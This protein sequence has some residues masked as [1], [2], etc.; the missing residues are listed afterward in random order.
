MISSEKPSA[1]YIQSLFDKLAPRYDL[2]NHLT[3]LGMAG[4]WRRKALEP[5]QAGMRVLDLGCGTG[6]LALDALRKMSSGEVVG[7][8]FSGAML[9][10]AR[11]RHARSGLNGKVRFRLVQKKAEELPFESEPYDVVVSGFVL[12]NIYE[13]IDAILSGVR[14]SLKNGG[15]IRFLDITEP[16]NAAARSFWKFYMRTFAALYGAVLFGKDYPPAYLTESAARFPRAKAFAK[17]LEEAG[18]KN[19]RSR[20]FMLG[21]VTLYEGEN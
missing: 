6:D 7:L 15:A 5:V 8:D 12:R 13:N 2:F 18:F 17:K 21:S 16:E 9:D 20:S 19:V 14:R 4:R 3:S 10:F 1:E 11:R